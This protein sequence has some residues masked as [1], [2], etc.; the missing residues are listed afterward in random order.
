M[1]QSMDEIN[2]VMQFAQIAQAAGP[3]GQM[4]LKVG[5]MI[6][7]V[8]EKLG[9]PARIRTSP[10]ERM[11]RMEQAAAMAQQAAQAAPEAVP[12]MIKAVA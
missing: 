1:A 8:A 2:K 9:V 5:E 11:Q 4:S 10:M 12:A 7:F 3:E 6:D